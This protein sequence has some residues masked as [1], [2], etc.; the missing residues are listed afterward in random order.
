MRL[1]V[2]NVLRSE[3][4]SPPCWHSIVIDRLFQWIHDIPFWF[5]FQY[6]PST[7]TFEIRG[8][9]ERSLAWCSLLGPMV[10]KVRQ[11]LQTPS[12]LSCSVSSRWWRAPSP[13]PYLSPQ[14][15]E[16]F[17][18]YRI[19]VKESVP[20]LVDSGFGSCVH[21][22]RWSGHSEHASMNATPPISVRANS[23]PLMTL[24][25]QKLSSTPATSISFLS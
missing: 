21:W 24:P 2:S 23:L 20:F 1:E 9:Y 18:F 25:S 16:K 13:F 8:N 19:E 7:T 10:L 4:D 5:L 15:K 22:R 14:A 12:N 3:I 11:T 6:K 17:D